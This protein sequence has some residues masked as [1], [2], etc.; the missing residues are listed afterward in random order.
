MQ[1]TPYFAGPFT[2]ECVG[3]EESCIVINVPWRATITGFAFNQVGGV[4]ADCAFELY[5]K[6]LACPPTGS[7]E[8]S[9]GAL[10][11]DKTM[12]SVFGERSFTAGTPLT[13]YDKSYPYVNQD[14]G[15]SPSNPVRR[16]YVRILPAG[17]GAK[18]FELA[19]QMLTSQLS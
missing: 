3:A 8:S 11:H 4:A 13:E 1:G 7:S 18:I 5:T 12:Y 15:G 17:T 16:L 6:A 14:E 2:L 10:D 19:L 9:S